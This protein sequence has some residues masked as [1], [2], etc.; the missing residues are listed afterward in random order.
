MAGAVVDVLAARGA[1]GVRPGVGG[2]VD[3]EPQPAPAGAR[4]ADLRRLL[5]GQAGQ[6]GVQ[7]DVV[8]HVVPRDPRGGL[9]PV[10]G[11]RQFGGQQG[12]QPLVV[13][14]PFGERVVQRAVTAG[15]LRLQAQLH[16][17]RHRVIGAQ[18]RVGQ[19]EQ[20]VRPCV[21]ALVQFLPELPQPLQRPETRHR[22]R[23]DRQIRIWADSMGRQQ[24]MAGSRESLQPGTGPWEGG[25]HGRFLS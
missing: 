25:Q 11:L 22:A 4:V 7:H 20:G 6:R 18:D 8:D 14:A 16:Q 21:Q 24:L 19:L 1:P 2:R 9:R 13:N 17:R 5:R 3:G 10:H 23:E 12:E 15:E